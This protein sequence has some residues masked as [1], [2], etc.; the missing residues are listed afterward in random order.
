M[1]FW[2]ALAFLVVATLG[3]LVVAV[4]RGLETYRT[5]KHLGG[6]VGAALDRITHST[7]EIEL[8]LQAAA[9]STERLGASL[10]R[11]AASRARLNVLT[12][13]LADA[14]ATLGRVYPSK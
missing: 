1:L 7:A 6:G 10:E 12:A 3:S 2:L 14:R 13:A 9:N 8:H 11:L 4:R 5:L